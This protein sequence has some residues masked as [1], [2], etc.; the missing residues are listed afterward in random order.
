MIQATSI[1]Y[2]SESVSEINQAVN[3]DLEALKGWLEGNKL[4]LNVAKTDAKIIGSNGKLRKIDSVYSTKPHF[5]IGSEDIKLVNEV[6]YLG[7][8][9]DHQLK[10]TS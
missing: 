9:V 2:A 8:Q 10:W 7:V 6:K 4:S 1:Y 5:K 3:A